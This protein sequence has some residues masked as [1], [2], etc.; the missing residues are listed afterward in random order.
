[1][2]GGRRRQTQAQVQVQVQG[3]WNRCGCD[4]RRRLPLLPCIKRLLV[5][6]REDPRNH[7]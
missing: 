4:A 2:G 6:Y 5:C 1:M 3:G 7:S